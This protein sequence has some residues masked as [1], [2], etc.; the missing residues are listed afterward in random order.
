MSAWRIQ[1][2]SE[3]IGTVQNDLK[4]YQILSINWSVSHKPIVSLK[5]PGFFDPTALLTLLCFIAILLP[6]S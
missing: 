2:I 6:V 1:Y 5:L 3:V 4:S